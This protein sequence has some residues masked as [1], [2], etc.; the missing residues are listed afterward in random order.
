M[1][2]F[3]D[4]FAFDFPPSA[5]VIKSCIGTKFMRRNMSKFLKNEE[6]CVH[7]AVKNSKE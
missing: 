7:E 2:H 3:H 5:L 6:L 1:Y 4:T